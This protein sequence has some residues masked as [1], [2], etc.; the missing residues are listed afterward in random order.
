MLM[1]L[2]PHT[3]CAPRP[4]PPG[5]ATPPVPE[6]PTAQQLSL[7]RDNWVLAETW[8]VVNSHQW[9]G[10]RVGLACERDPHKKAQAQRPRVGLRQGG[11][12]W[13][14]GEPQGRRTQAG[15]T[16]RSVSSF[17]LCKGVLSCDQ[18]RLRRPQSGEESEAAG[19]RPRQTV[20]PPRPPSDTWKKML[21]RLQLYIFEK[22]ILYFQKL[23][24]LPRM[25]QV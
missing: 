10:G 19:G 9:G 2:G 20:P 13:E 1:A 23:R 12:P 4:G 22:F 16:L 14:S 15:R 11:L 7:I 5:D 21:V 6:I 17:T 18:C 24:T 25:N 8:Q 3:R